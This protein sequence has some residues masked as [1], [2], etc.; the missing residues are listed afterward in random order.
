MLP[1]D[2]DQA[3]SLLSRLIAEVR[4]RLARLTELFAPIKG[5]WDEGTDYNRNLQAGLISDAGAKF[6]RFEQGSVK[7]KEFKL[8]RFG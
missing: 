6:H 7:T 5:D 1:I 8:M 4:L 3:R 2:P